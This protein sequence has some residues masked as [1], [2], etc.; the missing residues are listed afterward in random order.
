MRWYPIRGLSLVSK[1]ASRPNSSSPCVPHGY[2]VGGWES[3]KGWP[4]FPD[5]LHFYPGKTCQLKQSHGND[6]DKTDGGSAAL[7]ANADGG[8]SLGARENWQRPLHR[9]MKWKWESQFK[10]GTF[11]PQH[12]CK[13][14]FQFKSSTALT[15]TPSFS[16]LFEHL[17]S[18]LIS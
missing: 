7:S 14:H 16:M 8:L 13:A 18:K 5:G 9:E 4:V 12:P 6:E 17:N 10:E 2:M 1:Q 11:P 15:I 3:L